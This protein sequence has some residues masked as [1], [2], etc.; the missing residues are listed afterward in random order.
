M[1]I[2]HRGQLEFR[3]CRLVGTDQYGDAVSIAHGVESGFVGFIV[4]Q[5]YGNSPFEW[6][7][8]HRIPADFCSF[9]RYCVAGD[10]TRILAG[11]A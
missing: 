8:L 9:G 1:G 6:F 4:T 10:A 7:F 3:L 2:G 5:E 11:S